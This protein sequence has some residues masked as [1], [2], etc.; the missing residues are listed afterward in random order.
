MKCQLINIEEAIET[1]TLETEN[2]SLESLRSSITIKILIT[3]SFTRKTPTSIETS[4][5][6][7]KVLISSK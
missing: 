7:K 5:S 1:N 3:A 4:S 2:S 6:K